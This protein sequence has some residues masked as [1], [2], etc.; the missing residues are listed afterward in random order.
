MYDTESEIFLTVSI[1]ASRIFTDPTISS[2][3]STGETVKV[4]LT[5]EVLGPLYVAALHR[6]DI[7]KM[8]RNAA[9]VLRSYAKD[10]RVEATTDLERTAVNFAI[11][12]AESIAYNLWKSLD[13]PRT[14]PYGEMHLP[15]AHNHRNEE[16]SEQY[17]RQ[18]ADYSTDDA[19]KA[20]LGSSAKPKFEHSDDS[21]TDGADRPCL[22]SLKYVDKF[23]IRSKAFAGS[24]RTF[25]LSLHQ[26][27]RIKI[28]EVQI[29]SLQLFGT[30]TRPKRLQRTEKKGFSVKSTF[31]VL[32]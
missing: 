17:L 24:E 6:I 22:S 23:M 28:R 10:L 29:E 4:L 8:E 20:Y 27:Q 7:E 32:M 14:L 31:F 26:S 30:L 25:G 9:R 15:S 16:N 19:T 21:G 2:T 3:T 5:N 11:R 12:F 18:V 1:K 13:P